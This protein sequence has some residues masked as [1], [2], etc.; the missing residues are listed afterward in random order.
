MFLYAGDTEVGGFA[1]SS[2]DDL[3]YIQDFVTVDQVT[4]AVSVEFTDDAVANHFDQCV[5]AGIPPARFA[6]IWCHTHPGSSPD[7]SGTDEETFARVFGSCD[8][9]LM[10]ILSRTGRTYARLSFNTGPGGSMLLPVTVDWE[11]W[12]KVIENEQ[13]RMPELFEEWMGEFDRNIHPYQPPRAPVVTSD[14]LRPSRI[15]IEDGWNEFRDL[16]DDPMFDLLD[17]SEPGGMAGELEV[18]HDPFE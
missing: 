10:F 3:L 13:H 4:S 9:A 6:R 1:I 11:Q 15:S 17:Q 8:W 18:A 12:P 7:P 16:S 2:E 14:N 5:D